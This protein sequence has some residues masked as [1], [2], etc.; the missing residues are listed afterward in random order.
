MPPR[1]WR[2]GFLSFFPTDYKGV[3]E[4]GQIAGVGMLLAYIT[5]IT[6]LPALLTILH[7]PGEE[8]AIGYARAGAGRPTSWSATASR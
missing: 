2:A 4:L 7:P 6:V 5:S 3:S 1:R 8:E